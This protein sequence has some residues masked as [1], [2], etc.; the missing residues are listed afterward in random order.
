MSGNDGL[1]WYGGDGSA[2]DAY[3]NYAQDVQIV[4]RYG[5]VV[6]NDQSYNTGYGSGART[7][8]TSTSWVTVNIAGTSSTG[9]RHPS[10]SNVLKFTKLDNDSD[11]QVSVNFPYY[12]PGAGSG[13]GIR[14]RVS[15]DGGSTYAADLLTE[16]PAHGWGAAGY[17]G[18]QSGIL[19]YTWNTEGVLSNTLTGPIYIYFEMRC[20]STDT[21]YINQYQASYAKY[22]YIHI[23]EV[24][25][26]HA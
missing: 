4:S 24:S 9:D 19:N 23:K 21:A 20:W 6:N 12:M 16:G 18:D 17:G 5:L 22:G 7:D 25:R 11:L 13:V 10:S 8:L 14:M 26:N 2:D 1:H 3:N 15:G